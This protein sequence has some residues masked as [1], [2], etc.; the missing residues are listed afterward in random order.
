VFFV[1]VEIFDPADEHTVFIPGLSAGKT[2]ICNSTF[3]NGRGKKIGRLVVP[4]TTENLLLNAYRALAFGMTFVIHID[5][6]YSTNFEGYGTMLVGVAALDNKFHVVGYALVDKEDAKGHE[7]V[8]EMIK[9]GIETAV[10]KYRGG[11]I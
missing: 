4:L 5:V 7:L 2:F 3:D 11:L 9:A 6:E 8:L 10:R 1:L